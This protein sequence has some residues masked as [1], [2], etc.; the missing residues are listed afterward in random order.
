MAESARGAG[1]H[2]DGRR[3]DG[4]LRKHYTRPQG[5]V[6]GRGTPQRDR[7]ANILQPCAFRRQAPHSRATGNRSASTPQALGEVRQELR[8]P[9]RVVRGGVSPNADQ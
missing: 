4:G 2:G 3:K 7:G 6:G 8:R 1:G 5:R 9:G